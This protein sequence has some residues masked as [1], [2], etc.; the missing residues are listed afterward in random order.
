MI[1]SLIVSF[2]VALSFGSKTY[3]H[4]STG[5]I[6]SLEAYWGSFSPYTYCNN[7]KFA[8]GFKLKVEPNQGSGDDTSANGFQLICDDGEVL[9]AGNDKPWG[10]YSTRSCSSGAYIK[11]FRTKVETTGM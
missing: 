1:F 7:G 6:Q 11:G 4:D 3:R 9:S 5:V 2:Y 10:T 8:K